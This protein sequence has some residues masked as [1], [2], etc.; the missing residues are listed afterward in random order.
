MN[1]GGSPRGMRFACEHAE[2]CFVIL[3]GDDP[4]GWR[5]QIDA[6]KHTARDRFGRTVQVW[7]YAPCIQR[8][9]QAAAEDYLHHYAVTMEDTD[10]VNAW[11]AGLQAETKILDAGQIAAFRK[12][13]AA[14]AGGTILV[15]TAQR[16]ADRLEAMATAGLDG[17]LLTWVDFMDGLARFAEGV[18]P[19]PETRG[20]RQPFASAPAP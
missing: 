2:L 7:T 15:G 10:G 5:T 6:Y 9:T 4:Q 16:I 19:L 8:D 20:F 17:V 13:F 12:R 18:L 1:A 14:G 11:S 3:T